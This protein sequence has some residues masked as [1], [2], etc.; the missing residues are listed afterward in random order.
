MALERAAN[1]GIEEETFPFPEL[2]HG[3]VPNDRSG[4]SRD[5][6]QGRCGFWGGTSQRI[7]RGGGT[8]PASHGI[9][10]RCPSHRIGCSTAHW[11]DGRDLGGPGKRIGG[12]RQIGRKRRR[13][14]GGSN[15]GEGESFRRVLGKVGGRLG[16]VLINGKFWGAAESGTVITKIEG[17]ERDYFF[18]AIGICF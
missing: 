14:G 6:L 11:V 10:N 18:C 13:A 12:W 17:F 1:P 9:G 7:N 3:G 8:A 4:F 5:C 16:G 2:K 15:G